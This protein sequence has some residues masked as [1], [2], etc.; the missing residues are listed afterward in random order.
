L[1]SVTHRSESDRGSGE[2][3][4]ATIS[5]MRLMYSIGI[6]MAELFDDGLDFIMFSF[7]NGISNDFL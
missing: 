1:F 3:N 4:Q 5:G 6:V 2:P 7:E